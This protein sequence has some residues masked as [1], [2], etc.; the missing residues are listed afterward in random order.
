MVSPVRVHKCT[1][2][3]NT[4]CQIVEIPLPSPASIVYLMFTPLT[5]G[6]C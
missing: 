3:K 6:L 2:Q 1:D 4:E 5:G